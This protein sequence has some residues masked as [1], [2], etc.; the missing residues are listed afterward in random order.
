[1]SRAASLAL[2]LVIVA[3]L[4]AATRAEVVDSAPGGFTNKFSFEVSAVPTMAYQAVVRVGAWWSPDHTYSGSAANMTIDPRP[5][6]CFCEKLANGGGVQ[7]MTVLFAD[8][9]KMLRLSGGLGPI[10]TMAASAVMEWTFAE[11]P[12]GKTKVVMTYR[13]GG[14]TP[15]G[16]AA[17]AAGVDGVL[18]QQIDRLKRFIET[19]RP[20][21][22]K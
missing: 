17:M 5:G 6:G 1:M 19:G 10:Q 4:A 20:D 15:G 3:G 21:P 18:A 16:F 13:V 9:G 8:P 2:C 11:A 14:Y 7:H 12:G 22:A